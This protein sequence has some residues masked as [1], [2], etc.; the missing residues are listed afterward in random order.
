M[1]LTKLFFGLA[2]FIVFATACQENDSY[3]CDCTYSDGTN[4][5]TDSNVI[6][7]KSSL[8]DAER[9]CNVHETELLNSGATS[10]NCTVSIIM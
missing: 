6:G 4:T 8:G 7:E 1:N 2:I 5:L 3:R 9:D 10:A